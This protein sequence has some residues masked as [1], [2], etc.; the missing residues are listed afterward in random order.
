M[1]KF[2]VRLRFFFEKENSTVDSFDDKP[3]IIYLEKKIEA[4]FDKIFVKDFVKYLP[5]DRVYKSNKIVAL[6]VSVGSYISSPIYTD[7]FY[8][9]PGGEYGFDNINKE[10]FNKIVMPYV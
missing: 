7:H 5:E 1:T 10:Q 4:P 3:E 2:N 6:Q 9:I 8:F